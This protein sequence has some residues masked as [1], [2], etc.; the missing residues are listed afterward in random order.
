MKFKEPSFSADYLKGVKW[1]DFKRQY[2]NSSVI[3]VADDV[4]LYLMFKRQ[5]GR[6]VASM[7]RKLN[8]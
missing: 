3:D 6:K 1:T 2:M 4:E 8:K 7:E 5:S